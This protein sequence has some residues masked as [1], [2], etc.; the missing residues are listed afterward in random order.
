[1]TDTGAEQDVRATFDRILDAMRAGDPRALGVLL[2]DGST[3]LGSDPDEW[4]S[5]EELLAGLESA[6]SVEGERIGIE[7][8]ELNVHVHGDVAWVEGTGTFANA[9]GAQRA[10]RTTGV[11]VRREGQWRGA[12]SHTSIGVRNSEIFSG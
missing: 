6:T 3:H 10:V 9:Q 12:Q 1:M 4:W 7:V 11:F 2:A 8:G 5:K